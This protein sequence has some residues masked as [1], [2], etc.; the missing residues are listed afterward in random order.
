MSISPPTSPSP[1]PHDVTGGDSFDG[2]EISKF[3]PGLTVEQT[4]AWQIS[5]HPG[6]IPAFMSSM[7]HAPIFEQQALWSELSGKLRN[8]KLESDKGRCLPPSG[9]KVLF[10]LGRTDQVI[11][12]EELQADAT[13][14]L[15]GDLVEFLVMD[16]GH[17]IIMT[18]A[19]EIAVA[20]STLWAGQRV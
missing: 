10:I 19:S 15:G 3:L 9:E 1:P 17:E 5:Q 7:R 13:A 8:L 11:I 4:M 16:A 6:F 20:L 14:V 2:A 18:R 12:E